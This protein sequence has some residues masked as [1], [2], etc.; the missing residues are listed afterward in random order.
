MDGSG[1]GMSMGSALLAV[2][3]AMRWIGAMTETNNDDTEAMLI[4]DD[5]LD[6]PITLRNLVD[7]G[8]YH[9]RHRIT[10]IG[11]LSSVGSS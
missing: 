4:I 5:I 10:G 3:A 6:E 2:G 8:P 7:S 11:L 1:L 9:R